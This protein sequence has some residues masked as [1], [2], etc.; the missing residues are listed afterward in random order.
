MTDAAKGPD[1]GQLPRIMLPNV[2]SIGIEDNSEKQRCFIEV[3]S[4]L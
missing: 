4:V 1:P 2:Q 3:M